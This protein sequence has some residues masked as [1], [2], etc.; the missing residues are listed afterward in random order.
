MS[1][2]LEGIITDAQNLEHAMTTAMAACGN[3]ADLLIVGQT[4]A[5]AAARKLVVDALSR[6]RPALNP[7]GMT[8]SPW[9]QQFCLPLVDDENTL[10]VAATA[11]TVYGDD[12]NIRESDVRDDAKPAI[13]ALRE[14][15]DSLFA[16]LSGGAPPGSLLDLAMWLTSFRAAI[17]ALERKVV[18]ESEPDNPPQKYGPS[19]T[20][21]I[22]F[23][24]HKPVKI[25]K[26]NWKFL[27]AVWG[28]DRV[29]FSEVGAEVWGD[30]LKNDT[31]IRTRAVKVTSELYDNYEINLEFTCCDE[32]VSLIGDW[33]E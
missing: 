9:V 11:T 19:D 13:L 31:T 21:G 14:R 20:I 25:S 5:I 22:L 17:E 15:A 7:D 23:W 33:P 29:P 1:I 6:L 24:D 32:H 27:C 2:D 8:A 4:G 10:D 30:N 26:T 12:R 18:P 16:H 3:N 28:T